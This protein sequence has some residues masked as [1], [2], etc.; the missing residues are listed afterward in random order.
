MSFNWTGYVRITGNTYNVKDELKL[1]GAKWDAE[2][3]CWRA[4]AD[5][6]AFAQKIVD[7]A[8][9]QPRTPPVPKSAFEP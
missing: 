7:A 3:R 8:K 5:Q 4:P 6:A 9:G 1:L 2:V